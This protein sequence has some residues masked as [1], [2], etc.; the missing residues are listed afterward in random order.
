MP[1]KFLTVVLIIMTTLF[2]CGKD[3][4]KD[5]YPDPDEDS[6]IVKNDN[7]GSS[8]LPDTNNDPDLI[9]DDSNDNY[10]A[11]AEQDTDVADTTDDTEIKD[12]DI[13]TDNETDDA[14][15]DIEVIEVC[16]RK[17]CLTHE[18]CSIELGNCEG[19]S[20]SEKYVCFPDV[21]DFGYQGGGTCVEVNCSKDSDCRKDLGYMCIDFE[22]PV[23]EFDDAETGCLISAIG[24]SCTEEGKKI[25]QFGLEIALECI[26]GLWEP[27]YCENGDICQDGECIPE[28]TDSDETNDD[29]IIPPIE[30]C[31][32][33]DNTGEGN[34]DEGCDSDGDG[35]CDIDMI[36]IG[37]PGICPNGGQD[38]NDNNADIYPGSK[39]HIEGVDYDC[40]NRK[41]Y[42]AV[43]TLSVDDEL[44]E[45]CANGRQFSKAEFGPRYQQWPYADT[46]SGEKLVL[47]S[48]INVIGIHGKDTGL[49]ISAFVGTIH[50]NGT[51]IVTDGV[52]PPSSGNAY[53][54]SDLEWTQAQWRYFPEAV[55]TP[56]ADW[57]DKWF[58][59]SDWG[60]AIKAGKTG[61]APEV[62]GNLGTNP[63][64][65]GA[66]G[67]PQAGR[68]PTDFESF[69]IDA[70]TG[71][72]P[73]WIWDYNPTQLADAWLRIKITL[74]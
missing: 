37:K 26:D 21:T 16:F 3:E 19:Y 22:I 23:P 71:N 70:I 4:K 39:I 60:P 2:S 46:Y 51:T 8:V 1:G 49:A 67:L 14:D 55:P 15:T 20:D 36:V 32:N 68:C 53:T 42:Q 72:E 30:I 59:D 7:D 34:I 31:D 9:N 58:D 48:G 41:E 43:M 35:W 50:V 63:W 18:D 5:I 28:P 12:N 27:T 24:E 56:N 29:D 11:E 45:L 57:C 40:D 66:C 6:A 25:C 52:L 38:C 64:Y 10:D 65:G 62:W 73:K 61:T 69:Y 33:I 47:E 44:V 54:P 17:K 74:P 13:K